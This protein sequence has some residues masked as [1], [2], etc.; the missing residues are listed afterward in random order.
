M[1]GEEGDVGIARSVA[2]PISVFNY[3]SPFKVAAVKIPDRIF[4]AMRLLLGFL[5]LAS[6]DLAAAESPSLSPTALAASSN[7][8]V[9]YVACATGDRVLCFDV[10]S[11]KVFASIPMP[12]PPLGLV[13]SADDKQLY[14]TCAAPESKVCI[15]NTAKLKIVETIPT[16]HTAM[17]PVPSPDGKTLY[18]CNHF[19]N[20]VSVIDLPAKKELRRIAV[21]RQPV[22]ADLTKDGKYLLVANQLPAGRADAYEVA[23]VV[24]VIDLAK[25]KVVKEIHL[26]NGS[27]SLKDIRISPDGRYAVVSHLAG[28]INQ[29]TVQVRFGWINGNALTI[30]D[31][32][33]M[34][35]RYS[36]L[37]DE[38]NRG[39]GNPWG[40]AWSADG[41]TLAVA[42]A[43]THEASLID[44]PA[45]L[46]GLPAATN[47]VNKSTPMLSFLPTYDGLDDGLPYLTG[48]RE[49]VALAPGDYGPRA[50]IF[51]GQMFYTANY[52]S[53]TLG[54]ID[55][56][57]SKHQVKSLSL[58]PKPEMDAVRRGEF[59]FH[60]ATLCLQGW[61][62]CSSCHPGDARVDGFNWDLLNDGIGNPKNTRS[63]LLAHKTPPAM[64]LGV[65]ANAEMAVRAGIK[66]ILFT[67][68]PEAVAA[69]IDEYLKSLTPVPSPYLIHGKLSE[70]AK[71]GQK[72][73]PQAGCAD[74][75]VPG[76]YTD[77]HP[78]DVGTRN[79]HD[80]DTDKFYTPTLV[81]VWRTAPYLH[82][83]SAATIRDVMTTRN[84]HDEHGETSKLSDHEIDDLCEYVLSL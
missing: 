19:N 42:H 56:K 60:D 23:A 73:F 27:G 43:G 68:Q 45:L 51:A 62:S 79:Q 55:L 65:R 46:A 44:F 75:H 83:G 61:Q 77:L 52:F 39:A 40:M 49:R 74:C 80:Q 26:P 47:T 72:L 33:K 24:S 25:G 35:V 34:E 2:M 36:L 15:V 59:Y 54:A 84:P 16:G 4:P 82:D 58:G 12:E 78:H 41:K 71:R 29:P 38:Q 31:V 70:A 69:S 7:G 32:A 37:L 8:K 66:F 67:N 81:E 18:V 17:A 64:S 10:A 76:L 21:S 6:I 13:L 30:I 53:D 28:R 11:R 1:S 22:A 5:F 63:L 50:V 14:V 9:L 57:A 3:D 20:N 48:A